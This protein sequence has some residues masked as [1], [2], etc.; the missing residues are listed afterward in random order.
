[1]QTTR[2]YPP[3]SV[4]L[5]IWASRP[6]RQFRERPSLQQNNNSFT[7]QPVPAHH[8]RYIDGVLYSNEE[9][10]NEKY[11]YSDLV[12]AVTNVMR[13]R[14]RGYDPQLLNDR[15]WRAYCKAGSPKKFTV[16]MLNQMTQAC[17]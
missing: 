6:R 14:E 4:D 1:M 3:Q 10:T 8:S 11:V 5:G 13:C 2:R 7:E 12:T 15:C 17:L 9:I 16:V